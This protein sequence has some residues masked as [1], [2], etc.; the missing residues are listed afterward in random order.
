MEAWKKIESLTVAPT[1]TR[2]LLPQNI[3]SHSTVGGEDLYNVVVV[4]PIK[5]EAFYAARAAI[6]ALT[7]R[8]RTTEGCLKYDW[9]QDVREPGVVVI[10]ESYTKEEAFNAHVES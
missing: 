9:Y 6:E 2:V 10:L 5:G 1:I 8:S 4:V 7:K 3:S